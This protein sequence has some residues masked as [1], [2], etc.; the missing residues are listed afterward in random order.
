MIT[1]ENEIPFV[2]KG[3]TGRII[4]TPEFDRCSHIAAKWPDP[5]ERAG[6]EAAIAEQAR[7]QMGTVA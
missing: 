2:R 7:R 6:M 1:H 3:Q 4:P 5:K